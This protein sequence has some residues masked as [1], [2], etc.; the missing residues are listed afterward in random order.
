MGSS[1]CSFSLGPPADTMADPFAG[2]VVI[3]VVG[4]GMM[5]SAHAY[6]WSQSQRRGRMLWTY[7]DSEERR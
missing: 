3:G 1:L 2:D 4:T 6:R 7:G 5:A